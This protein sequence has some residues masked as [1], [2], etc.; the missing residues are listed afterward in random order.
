MEDPVAEIP[1]V[2]HLL[3]QSLPS[4]QK[5]TI[6]RFFTPSASF[7][8]P[9]CRTGSFDGS[10]WLI[11]QIY[12]FY[13]I[14]SPHIDLEIHSVAFD[15]PNLTLYV[16]ISQIFRLLIIPFYKA[17]ARLTVILTLSPSTTHVPE[18]D[19]SLSSSWLSASE[20]SPDRSSSHSHHP[21]STSTT[22]YYISAQEDLY[23][24]SEVV[25]FVLPFGIG[26]ML[27]L[28]WHSFSTAFCVCAAWVLWPIAWAEERE[29]LPLTGGWR[30][31]RGYEGKEV[32]RKKED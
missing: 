26:V 10:R 5:Q 13:K 3:T 17:N 8:H 29:F 11:I 30:I 32:G 24:I 9:L 18:A 19:H 31:R 23:Q 28:V 4:V 16:T 1:H 15:K 12:R 7:T 6:E 2:I 14:M 27:T 21:R 22:L 25:K 20:H